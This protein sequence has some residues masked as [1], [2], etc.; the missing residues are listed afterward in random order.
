MRSCVVWCC[1]EMPAGGGF[2]SQKLGAAQGLLTSVE[3]CEWQWPVARVVAK[4]EGATGSGS[5]SGQ[6]S[7]EGEG[8]GCGEG[9]RI[10][11][12]VEWQR[13]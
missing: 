4:K 13:R 12:G 8:A 6:E 3:E 11:I 2:S 1:G 7:L 9:E 5:S 10:V